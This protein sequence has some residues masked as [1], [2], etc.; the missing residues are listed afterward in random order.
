MGRTTTGGIA[1][2][3]EKGCGCLGVWVVILIIGDVVWGVQGM[4]GGIKGC[5]EDRAL[6]PFES[7]LASYL[8]A[9]IGKAKRD[10]YV[11]GRVI[12][13]DATNGSFD[14]DVYFA[15]DDDIRASRP[16][17]VGTVLVTE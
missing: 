9:P 14:H 13:V 8:A 4:Y 10:D 11:K 17:E 16:E 1:G 3:S 2:A 7:Q 5:D 6:S 12:A 15:L